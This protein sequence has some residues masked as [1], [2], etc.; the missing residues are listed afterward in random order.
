[1]APVIINQGDLYKFMQ[2][3]ENR[4]TNLRF[5]CMTALIHTNYND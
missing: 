3:T 2:Q 1:V 5:T 4:L